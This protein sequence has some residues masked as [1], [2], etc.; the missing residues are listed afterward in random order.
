MNEKSFRNTIIVISSVATVM[1]GVLIYLTLTKSSE[2]LQF[3]VAMG[4][5][6]FLLVGSYAFVVTGTTQ[7]RGRDKEQMGARQNRLDPDADAGADSDNN[8]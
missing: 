2:Y 1:V 7:S 5:F 6:A 4:L 8:S 3:G